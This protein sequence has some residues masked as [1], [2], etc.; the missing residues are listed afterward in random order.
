M[1]VVRRMICLHLVVCLA[2]GLC[3]ASAASHHVALGG[4]NAM[5]GDLGITL[6]EGIPLRPPYYT[7]AADAPVLDKGEIISL[8]A[9]ICG[10]ESFEDMEEFGNAKEEWFRQYLDLPN[11]RTSDELGSSGV[12]KPPG[13]Q[14]PSKTR[15]MG[16][17]I[18]REDPHKI[19]CVYPEGAVRNSGFIHESR[20]EFKL[21]IRVH[22]RTGISRPCLHHPCR[23]G[24]S[25]C[26]SCRRGRPWLS[27]CFSF[28]LVIASSYASRRTA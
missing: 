5:S 16:Q 2:L 26:R 25:S 17:Q 24:L 1:H 23:R 12:H 19:R 18:P 10:C 9:V 7:F 6:A 4:E 15:R 14:R 27:S 3:F 8:C 13:N 20:E 11:A 22:L 21:G 28:F